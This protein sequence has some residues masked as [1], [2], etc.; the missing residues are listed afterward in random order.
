MTGMTSEKGRPVHSR[1]RRGACGSVVILLWI[2]GAVAAIPTF[3]RPDGGEGASGTAGAAARIELGRVNVISGRESGSIPV[4]LSSDAVVDLRTATKRLRGPNPNIGIR[5][6]GRFVGFALVGQPFTRVR[7]RG[8][9]LLAG[10]FADCSAPACDPTEWP[11]NYVNGLAPGRGRVVL[12]RGDYRLFLIADGAP[13]RIRLKFIDGPSGKAVL[14]PA[15]TNAID[16]QTPATRFWNDQGQTMWWAGSHFSGGQIGFSVTSVFVTADQLNGTEL[17]V[18]QY[19]R[20]GP[21]PEEIAYGPHC[22]LLSNAM[23]SGA[24]FVLA[25]YSDDQFILILMLG[26]HEQGVGL[27]NPDGTRG[28]GVW[29]R[30]PGD[31]DRFGANAFFVRLR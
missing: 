11:I 20:P 15:P 16:L 31:V 12:K 30:S 21:P 13:V 19:N 18:C 22:S 17:G 29:F 2:Y 10:R 7:E 26:Y 23:G 3:A 8:R 27:E 1:L 25:P 24:E 4:H 5:G 28:L 6:P 14:S 9:F